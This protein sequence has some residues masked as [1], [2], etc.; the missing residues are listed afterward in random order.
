[1]TNQSKELHFVKD[2]EAREVNSGRGR[3]PSTAV[4]GE[5]LHLVRD[6]SR[7]SDTTNEIV[8]GPLVQRPL[9][10]VKDRKPSRSL[11]R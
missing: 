8:D 10:F 3:H 5:E 11:G 7:W 6:G 1:M 9:K 4:E 2:D